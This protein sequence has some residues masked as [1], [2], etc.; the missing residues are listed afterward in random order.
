MTKTNVKGKAARACPDYS[1]DVGYA[2]VTDE[3]AAHELLLK[4]LHPN[5]L[6]CP[7]CH[8]HDVAPVNSDALPA[9]YVCGSCG[10]E[11][12]IL[13][14]T[15]MEGLDISL[16]E[17]WW[18]LF[19]FTS[20]PM[21]SAPQDLVAR[22]GWDP[23]LAHTVF[24]RLLMACGQSPR[25]LREPAEMDWTYLTRRDGNRQSRPLYVI[26]LR[27]RHTSN[28][29]GLQIIRD[30]T[31]ATISRVVYRHL[32]HGMTLFTDSHRSNVALQSLQLLRDSKQFFVN[33]E[34]LEYVKGPASTNSLE[35]FWTRLKVF[36]RR[37]DWFSHRS[38]THCL[39]GV[40]WWENNRLHS[41]QDRIDHLAQGM[42]RKP[43]RKTDHQIG[44][45]AHF[46]EQSTMGLESK[47][48]PGPGR[49][50]AGPARL[51][52]PGSGDSFPDLRFQQDIP[53]E[54]AA[55]AWFGKAWFGKDFDQD[56]K[57]PPCPRCVRG[58]RVSPNGQRSSMPY[59]CQ[60]CRKDFSFK[61]ETVMHRS[62]LSLRQW[63]HALLIWTGGDGPATAD[64][65][66]RRMGLSQGTGDDVNRA[67][68]MATTEDTDDPRL[69]P[70]PTLA[71]DCGLWWFRLGNPDQDDSREPAWVVILQ[72]YTTKR[73]IVGRVAESPGRSRDAARRFAFRQMLQSGGSGC[74]GRSPAPREPDMVPSMWIWKTRPGSRTSGEWKTRC[75]PYS[76]TCTGAFRM[77]I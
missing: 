15:L 36:L 46:E 25:K 40:E 57:L 50:S 59:R 28:L 41:H 21:V 44:N 7:S 47:P 48:A 74:S 63:L 45:P 26:A 3:A 55:A 9:M 58:S 37:Y 8:S 66:E 27:G 72:G 38:L 2:I 29:A 20:G 13:T 75:K 51:W 35:G 42:K 16:R 69:E 76:E 24:L 39:A 65:L 54:L 53:D 14:D 62:R 43:R 56:K 52:M 67:I 71:E 17:W 73:V 10:K 22:M 6:Q 49:R 11:F 32:Y 23:D 34:K 70:H 4:A 61:T 19:V 68:L 18:V 31:V 77:I 30:E 5:G 60:R 1:D 64:E 12:T 33:H